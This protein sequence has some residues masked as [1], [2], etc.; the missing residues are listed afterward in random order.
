MDLKE[1]KALYKFFKNTDLVEFESE[2]EKGK[3]RFSSRR[4]LSLKR[5]WKPPESLLA[6]VEPQAAY[7][8]KRRRASY[9]RGRR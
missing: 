9:S 7:V 4:R 3:V 5:G 6:E 8:L 2:S 1:I